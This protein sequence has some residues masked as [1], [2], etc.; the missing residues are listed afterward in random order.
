MGW[1]AR[2]VKWVSKSL[3]GIINKMRLKVRKKLEVLQKQKVQKAEKQEEHQ[4]GVKKKVVYN[5]SSKKLLDEQIIFGIEFWYYS[6]KVSAGGV[7]TS[8]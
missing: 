4:P 7:C 5:N 1:V 3:K 2:T 6:E 8:N